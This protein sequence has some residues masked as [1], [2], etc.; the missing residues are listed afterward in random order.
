M[1]L[2]GLTGGRA[3]AVPAT[4]STPLADASLS[5]SAEVLT[6][7]PLG[8]QP[9]ARARLV[10]VDASVAG[11]LVTQFFAQVYGVTEPI[12]PV[13]SWNDVAR[14]IGA[15]ASIGELYILS[16]AVYGAISIDG[17]QKTP[18]QVAD[19][20]QPIMPPTSS[21]RIEGCVLG[22]ALDGLHDLAVRLKVAQVQ[23]WTYW[24]VLDWWNVPPTGDINA[25]LAQFSPLA[26]A[27]QPY[28]P[29]S[30]DGLRT[31]D[32]PTQEA[33]FTASALAL[34]AEYFVEVY[35]SHAKP[36]FG[37]A[38]QAGGVN[39]T[40]HVPRGAAQY[41]LVDSAGAQSALDALL[42]SSRPPFCRVVMTPWQ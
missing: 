37:S 6:Q 4:P 27:A 3:L 30:P 25:A 17:S 32:V 24:H 33:A 7:A 15:Y 9:A 18:S 12:T 26:A 28:L 11:T 1:S 13:S 31:I 16:H 5:R 10:L 40:L 8:T 23:A 35:G 2:P 36:N 21:F 20:L 38:L 19:L 34:A 39:P 41:R 29:A 14:E 42:N 22:H